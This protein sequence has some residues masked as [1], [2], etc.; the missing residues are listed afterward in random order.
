VGVKPG[1]AGKGVAV[2]DAPERYAR[3]L[4]DWCHREIMMGL[5]NDYVSEFS[6]KILVFPDD[7]DGDFDETRATAAGFF[8]A[9]IVHTGVAYCDGVP[10]ADVMDEHS[11]ELLLIY[12]ALYGTKAAARTSERMDMFDHED[13]LVVTRMALRPEFRGQGLGLASLWHLMRWHSNLGV[14]AMYVNPGQEF[15][16]RNDITDCFSKMHL[17]L[18][19]NVDAKAGRERMMGYFAKIGFVPRGKDGVMALSTKSGIPV[20]DEIIPWIGD[21][22][23]GRGAR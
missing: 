7:L 5:G 23:R 2:P 13:I 19:E 8:D 4:Y 10:L 22:H 12:K 16:K 14:V 20:P 1:V 21:A 11:D 18:F 17:D 15:A 6:G 3:I 9:A